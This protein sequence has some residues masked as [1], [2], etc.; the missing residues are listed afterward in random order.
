MGISQGEA[1]PLM[2]PVYFLPVAEAELV[3]AQTWYDERAAGLG[4]RFFFAVDGVVSRIGGN[5][6]QFP[7]IRGELRRALVPRFPYA[8]FFR[9]ED[10]RA[11]VVACAHTSRAPFYWRQ[12]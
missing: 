7:L 11:Y 10:E 3:A 4:D 6:V 2:L 1:S 8:L 9:V 5:A 12:G